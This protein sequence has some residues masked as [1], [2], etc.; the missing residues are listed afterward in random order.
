MFDGTIRGPRVIS[1]SGSSFQ[2]S[3]GP[4]R[5]TQ[6]RFDVYSSIR[7][8]AA[9]KI[10]DSLLSKLYYKQQIKLLKFDLA[11]LISEVNK[12]FLD[13]NLVENW[14]I[15]QVV[16]YHPILRLIRIITAIHGNFP[17]LISNSLKN[18]SVKFIINWCNLPISH[19][20][21]VFL[22]ENDQTRTQ[23]I[24]LI[25]R[26]VRLFYKFEPH[27]ELK[28]ALKVQNLVLKLEPLSLDEQQ[29]IK[30][31][32]IIIIT[33][34]YP[35]TLV[36]A[37]LTGDCLQ[38]LFGL[39]IFLKPL[40]NDVKEAFELFVKFWSA[41]QLTVP[42]EHLL[43]VL[44][45]TIHEN[46]LIG[47]STINDQSHTTQT[48][49]SDSPH[50]RG[51]KGNVREFEEL[52]EEMMKNC[53]EKLPLE[54]T[55]NSVK[56]NL[57]EENLKTELQSYT[58]NNHLQLLH[59]NL[60]ISS[61]SSWENNTNA[62]GLNNVLPV[63]YH[64]FYNLLNLLKAIVEED[65]LTQRTL[66]KQLESILNVLFVTF[67]HFPDPPNL[68]ALQSKYFFWTK[69]LCLP[70]L[71]RNLILIIIQLL[72]PVHQKPYFL[73]TS[74]D[75]I[76]YKLVNSFTTS[77]VNPLELDS[78]VANILL[79]GSTITILLVLFKTHLA[80][81]CDNN[82]LILFS[83]LDQEN[84]NYSTFSS[85]WH[86]FCQ[87]I[88]HSLKIMYDSEIIKIEEGVR[89]L[90]S[91]ED[92]IWVSNI[93]NH[94]FWYKLNQKR[95]TEFSFR[96]SDFYPHSIICN[97]N[98]E[99]KAPSH[100]SYTTTTVSGA[101]V[102][103][104]NIAN[105]MNTMISDTCVEIGKLARKFNERFYRLSGSNSPMW[106]IPE[107]EKSILHFVGSENKSNSSQP[108]VLVSHILDYIPHTISFKN[109]LLV[110]YN[111]INKDKAQCR[112]PM[113]DIIGSSVYI[114]RRQFIV[115]DGI[116]TLGNLNNHQLKQVFR[117]LFVDENGIEE[118]G[119]DGGGLFKEFLITLC[120]LIFDP[121]YGI[122][123]EVPEERSYYPCPNS[124]IIHENHLE[125]F[126]FIGK[127]VG[128][129]LY[130]QI[131]IEP[132]LSRLLL[133][134][135]LKR[136]NT[137]DDLK[138]FDSALYRNITMLRGMSESEIEDLGLTFTCTT[139]CFGSTIQEDLIP[140]GHNTRVTKQN[141]ESFIHQF[142]NFK[143][144]RMIES[145]C[146]AFLQGLSSII[147]L[148]WLQMFSP[149]ELELLIS[150][151][152]EAIDISDL[153]KNTVYAGGF[154]ENN[155][156][157]QWL[158]EILDEYD[159]NERSSFLWFVTCC[160]RSPLMGFKQLQPP[161]CV[162]KEPDPNRL[163][164]V[165]TCLN[166]LKLPESTSKEVLKS[167]IVDAMSLSK[168]FGLH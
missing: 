53:S 32:R 65:L 21:F 54:I 125:L 114:I 121:T 78:S 102:N 145:Q 112:N 35:K 160:K 74:Y 137:L 26:Y 124:G 157:I 150:G 34:W 40:I 66:S 117:V 47:S 122:F 37:L 49:K 51:N 6:A 87:L 44:K 68:Y 108:S 156:T 104:I 115:E 155:P 8:K 96:V 110:F 111:Y 92:A 105:T 9:K 101:S 164:S 132:V 123:E 84:S 4:N 38:E 15:D 57:I 72:L 17:D 138:L 46:F 165:S 126:C 166:L 98:I 70:N 90:M 129:A 103:S 29:F 7:N 14:G 100:Y 141:L 113:I 77:E 94:M 168:G 127:I 120:T 161:F 41:P 134:L 83:H 147:P 25:T 128:K 82:I 61:N 76:L 135:I 58:F 16:S 63:Y 106:I 45:S 55:L 18:D 107:A 43:E 2:T 30:F 5:K 159:N 20:S 142:S 42:K 11:D 24:L 162:H 64:V 1:L 152:S 139:Q 60:V 88:N 144:N 86:A 151:S 23:F 140:N 97:C 39:S 116:S 163:P 27:L 71:N 69:F 56:M 93:L 3:S 12:F 167:K 13:F 75:Y 85:L 131:L 146:S 118:Q 10:K 148:E 59:Y 119:V 50:F 79:S 33:N 28:N 31:M 130:E 89:A 67:C 52:V 149:S 95:V 81:C 19:Y 143:C 62:N 109:R 91:V 48:I 80:K 136:R 99:V 153:R 22:L 133:N 73:N 154:D 36:R 158:W